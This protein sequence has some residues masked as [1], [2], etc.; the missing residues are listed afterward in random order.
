VAHAWT[1]DLGRQASST[2]GGW[3][4]LD[5]RS[6]TTRAELQPRQWRGYNGN[7][8]FVDEFFERHPRAARARLDI[9]LG[10]RD[11]GWLLTPA[12]DETPEEAAFRDRLA[13]VIFNELRADCRQLNRQLQ[14]SWRDV[15]SQAA[16][17]AWQGNALFERTWYKD[18]SATAGRGA[19]LELF[20]VHPSTIAEFKDPGGVLEY[21]RQSSLSTAGGYRDIPAHKL[22]FIRPFGTSG[23]WEG[24]TPARSL[25]FLLEVAWSLYT[26]KA[27]HA[28]NAGGVMTVEQFAADLGDV[29]GEN[30]DEVDRIL[31]EF[32]FGNAKAMALPYGLKANFFAPPGG[33]TDTVE[34][35][36]YV[37]GAVDHLLG[38]WV[39]SLG[40]TAGSGS[41]AL[42]E[43]LEVQDQLRWRRFLNTIGAAFTGMFETLRAELG[44]PS[45]VRVP[46]LEVPAASETIPL[47]EFSAAVTAGLQVGALRPTPGLTREW[48]M[49]ANLPDEVVE[50]QLAAAATQAEPPAASGAAEAVEPPAPVTAPVRSTLAQRMGLRAADDDSFDVPERVR[51]NARRGLELR[52]EHGRGGTEVGV[53]RARDLSNGRVSGDT[54]GRMRS[55]F[56][57]HAVD[58]EHR[59]DETSA[60]NIAWLLWGG[61]SGR[62][63]VESE[64]FDEMFASDTGCGC[65]AC[66]V[67][68]A[69]SVTN[70]DA[71]GEPVEFFREFIDLEFDVA[72]NEN[73]RTRARLDGEFEAAMKAIRDDH[74]ADLRFALTPV[75]GAPAL[76]ADRVE[77]LTDAI[78]DTYAERYAAA[79][80][81]HVEAVQ[82]ATATA[83]QGERARRGASAAAASR[84]NA[85]ALLD[86]VEGEVAA[87]ER[88]IARQARVAAN[89]VQE[90][91]LDQFDA[92]AKPEQ[93]ASRI[94]PSGLSS[95]AQSIANRAEGNGR[96]IEAV[97]EGSQDLVPVE[98]IR[99]SVN[100]KRRCQTCQDRDGLRWSLRT[101]EEVEAFA[102]DA[103]STVPDPECEG[104]ER[105]CR[106]GHLVRYGRLA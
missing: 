61:D 77:Q 20:H 85:P 11:A 104:T 27:R 51:A 74:V 23:Q 82:R 48:A 8:G 55:F 2:V 94:R 19:R 49:R 47:D 1:G 22:L 37:D 72:W 59:D 73:D 31:D 38:S 84:E 7:P 57:R 9:E 62:R 41:R 13:G 45:S 86:W 100:D 60:A 65:G 75:A 16:S 97:V 53:A 70:T 78:R 68:A 106:C 99:T 71:N 43:T 96:L 39:A 93:L 21:V 105:R 12:A 28:R 81:D 24:W 32:E 67:N 58:A 83:S 6:R 5:R 40:L 80:D 50:E 18:P 101:P 54:I 25:G 34:F 17:T 92:G 46:T 3:S 76:S 89:R 14:G 64:T 95:H 26:A 52:R 42:G 79:I 90:D 56:A 102:A 35:L 69:D 91:I 15:V 66:E 30:Q 63:W 29:L 10:V 87:T 44:Y 88:A 36:K 103:L 98:V 33:G 4:G